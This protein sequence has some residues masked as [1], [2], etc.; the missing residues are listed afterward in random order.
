MADVPKFDIFPYTLSKNSVTV[1]T[2]FDGAFQLS[3]NADRSASAD[4][5]L[6]PCFDVLGFQCIPHIGLSL[7]FFFCFFFFSVFSFCSI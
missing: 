1:G 2:Y 5:L 3:I 4:P 6:I 7:A